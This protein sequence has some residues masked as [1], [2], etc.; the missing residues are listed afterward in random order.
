MDPSFEFAASLLAGL[1]LL[2][3]GNKLVSDHLKLLTGRHFRDRI[4]FLNA[5]PLAAALAG[6]LSGFVTWN[7]RTT[8]YIVASFVHSRLMSVRQAMPIALWA[9]TGCALLVYTAVL[10]LKTLVLLLVGFS[11]LCL[12]FEAP[13]R[14]RN[15]YGA[16]FGLALLLLG[17]TLIKASE[18]GFL[19][20]TQ[21]AALHGLLKASPLFSF[22]LG[23]LLT[24]LAQSH[25]SIILVALA[26]TEAG[27]F[28]TLDPVVMIVL[29]AHAGNSANTYLF[30]WRFTGLSRQVVIAET[31]C[32][33]TGV[34]LFAGIVAAGHGWDYPV[35][36]AF[37]RWWTLDIARQAAA[38]TLLFNLTVPL[39]CSAL[40]T[41]YLTLVQRVCPASDDDSQA[42]TVYLQAYMGNQ[43]ET[44][45]L[46]A[47]QEHLRLLKRLPA[48]LDELRLTRER[49]GGPGPTAYHQA[50][51]SLSGLVLEFLLEA[52]QRDAALETS[53]RL[54]N[55]Q[56]RQRLLV[57][58]EEDLFGL[59]EI[60][61]DRRGQGKAGR[62][63]LSI[64]ESLDTLLLTAIAAAES[65]DAHERELLSVMTADRGEMMERTRKH[66]LSM[67]QSL[68]PDDR[69]LI[70]YI[71][72]LFERTAWSIGQYGR[73][74]DRTAA[75]AAGGAPEP[76]A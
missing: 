60:L 61:R 4:P 69:S 62:L 71:T 38:V 68:T 2:L 18:A 25:L 50:F 49:S 7:S 11:G 74:L 8:T 66:Y 30:G 39:F 21:R 64:V 6:I 52:L 28:P 59:F 48:Y 33:A 13:S 31:L 46:L 54:L 41:P 29:G 75:R 15:T 72:H 53:E 1:G 51:G 10:P 3:A 22:L 36:N 35:L 32:A 37:A 47:E 67:E 58:I 42:H 55:L 43:P 16:V 5:H 56:N 76:S 40:L 70:L 34:V 44:A 27:F 9:N 65:G 26:M 17:L 20:D 63:G 57:A 14:Y 73:L 19:I 12:F 45:A 24:L 23:L